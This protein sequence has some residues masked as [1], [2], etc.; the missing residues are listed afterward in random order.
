MANSHENSQ[1]LK[2]LY[3]KKA[4]GESLNENLLEI[5]TR[6]GIDIPAELWPRYESTKPSLDALIKQLKNEGIDSESPLAVLL[7]QKWEDKKPY[8]QPHD[9]LPPNLPIWKGNLK[10]VTTFRLSGKRY[11]ILNKVEANE[12]EGTACYFDP[13]TGQKECA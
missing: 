5:L 9:T 7:K 12:A 3:A 8:I 4:S 2:N 10:G 11:G 6:K 1:I 13:D